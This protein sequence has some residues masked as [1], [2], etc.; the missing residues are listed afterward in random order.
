MKLPPRSHRRARLKFEL[1]EDRI[2]PTSSTVTTLLD[3]VNAGD[4]VISLREAII[5][6]EADPEADTIDFDPSL[7]K[8]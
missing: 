2:T 8:P 7:S 1:L 5:A 4:G 3:T 6:A